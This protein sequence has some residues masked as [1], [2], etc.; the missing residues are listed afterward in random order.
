M[1][2]KRKVKNFE[3]FLDFFPKFLKTLPI[4]EISMDNEEKFCENGIIENEKIC[5]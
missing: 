5:S 1:E 4:C 3:K 2:V